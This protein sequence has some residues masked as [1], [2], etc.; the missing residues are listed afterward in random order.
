MPVVAEGLFSYQFG[1]SERV[2]VDLA[3]EFRRRG[4]QVVCFAFQDSD[5]P[6]RV[7]LER[8]GIRCLEMNYL[9][10]SKFRGSLRIVRRLLY[11]W[12]FWRMFAERARRRPARA[13]FW[14]HDPVRH[15]CAPCRDQ[16]HRHD[17]A[18]TGNIDCEPGRSQTRRAP[19][20][21]CE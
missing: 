21:L 2:G 10:Y 9:K 15:R 7:E 18:R 1:G 14:S 20:P 19:L 13:S 4:F 17:G 11:F 16:T 12:K 8:A 6:M 5:G 3:L